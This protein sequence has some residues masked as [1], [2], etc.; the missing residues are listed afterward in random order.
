MKFESLGLSE[1]ILRAITAEGYTVPTPIQIKAIPHV[2]QGEDLLGCAQTGTGKTAAF[3]LPILHRLT[4]SDQHSAV[5]GQMS[6]DSHQPSAVS[7]QHRSENHAHHAHHTDHAKAAQHGAHAGHAHHGTHNRHGTHVRSHLRCLILA[8]TRE[9]AAQIGDSFRAYGRHVR[10]R[11][12]VIFGGV[13]QHHQVRALKAGVDILIA[14]PGRLLDLMNQ[15]YVDLKAIEIFVLD[16]A[17]RM[18]DMGFIPD[19]RKIV[20]V[21]PQKRQTL[22]FSATMPDDIRRLA[23]S[24]LHNP[25]SVAVNPVASTVELI[26]QQVY[27]VQKSDKPVLLTHLLKANGMGRTLVF[28]RTKHGADKV[29]KHLDRAGIRA[30]AIHGNKSQNHRTRTL[31]DFKS[32]TPPV[33][34]ATD[35]ASRGID[36]DNITHVVNFDVPN[37]PETYVHRIGRT[38]RAGASGIAISFCDREERGDLKA[39]ERLTRQPIEVISHQLSFAAS[40]GAGAA[41]SGT[42]PK[43]HD[44]P[45]MHD[46]HVDHGE[47]ERGH[48][49]RGDGESER[50]QHRRSD[51]HGGREH[52]VRQ[53][54]APR[55][56]G[57]RRVHGGTKSQ[58]S[59]GHHHTSGK[60][61]HAKHAH[62]VKAGHSTGESRGG[63]GGRGG[64]RT[65]GETSHRAHGEAAHSERDGAAAK[66]RGFQG[67]GRGRPQRGRGA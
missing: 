54:H 20:K 43:V 24:I 52:G 58:D 56:G 47:G 51:K 22:F 11:H 25:V 38:A 3:A 14:T 30:Q 67:K 45:R 48:R 16:E 28:T 1:P 35:I 21:I 53:S 18:L 15:G 59:R 12:T 10:L 8:P 34:V 64:H 9:L 42:G 31:A 41:K 6:A 63:Q 33:L 27:F 19:I 57:A 44:E 39:I 23:D 37:I 65:H 60:P 46:R 4:A 26:T 17:D 49:R 50:G 40:A 36:V 32:K 62:P 2:L 55:T 29:V 5:S 13:N 66:R 7:G 61:G